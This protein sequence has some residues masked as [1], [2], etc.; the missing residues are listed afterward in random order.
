MHVVRT[1][2]LHRHQLV[3]ET[4]SRR[5]SSHPNIR[6]VGVGT[7][8]TEARNSVRLLRPDVVVVDLGI[9]HGSALTLITELTTSP[10][11]VGVVALLDGANGAAATRSIR[12]GANGA[13]HSEEDVSEL[14]SA[15]VAVGNGEGWMPPDLLGYALSELRA[16][17]PPPNR[18]VERLS[19][20]TTREREVLDHMVAGHD[21]AT[22]AH[23]LTVSI[24]TVRTHTQNILTKL[25]VHSGLEA[26]SLAR[27]AGDGYHRVS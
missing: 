17:A 1:F 19:R 5:L 8:P 21:R 14:I 18:Y 4:L 6:T 16:C 27:R 13:T 3:A 11:S 20:L 7:S 23:E 10:P 9:N 15:V 12:A 24:N 2:V 22:I 26:V 25:D